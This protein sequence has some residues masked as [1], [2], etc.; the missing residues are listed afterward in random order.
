[1]TKDRWVA[2][3]RWRWVVYAVAC[4]LLALGFDFQPPSSRFRKIETQQVANTAAVD[5]LKLEHQHIESY[6]RALAVAQCIDRPR[7]DWQLMG[8]PCEDLLRGRV[9]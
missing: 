3:A 4:F 2:L 9:P 7:R 6:L 8:L 5:S 1:M